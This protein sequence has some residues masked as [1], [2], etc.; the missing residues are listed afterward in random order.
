MGSEEHKLP[1]VQKKLF[2]SGFLWGAATSSHQVEGGTLN[3]WSEWEK[4]NAERLAGEAEK[5]WQ[6]WQKKKFPE[7]F[8]LQ[9]YLSGR[10]CDHYNRYE[11]DFELAKNLG[12]NAHRFSI[13]WSRIEPEEGKFSE[14]GIEHYQKVIAAL[15]NRGMEPFVTL[16]HWTNPLW[17][18]AK[19]GCESR[20]F[21]FYFSRY[22][23][24]VVERL[25]D[26][27]TFW[28][29]LNEPTSVIAD[30]YISGVW[31][32]QKKSLIATWKVFKNFAKA[33]KE[34]YKAI[35]SVSAKAQVG[36]AN[37]LQSF[38]V[39]RENSWLDKLGVLVG[40][41]FVNHRMLDMTKGHHDFLTAQFYFHNR[42]KFPRKIRLDD[43][44]VSDL[45]WEIFP[46]GIYF[47]INWLKK[48]GLPIY[49]TENGLAD[50]DDSRRTQFIKDHLYWIYKSISEGADVRGYFHWSL[51]DNF[52]WD[53]GFWPRFGLIEIDYKTLERKIRPSAYVY[54][55]IIENNRL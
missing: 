31:P 28:I 9:N 45:N 39:Y 17:L 8:D 34:A 41:Y 4:Q 21:A 37:I 6:D 27:V 23:K 40:S 52:E 22:A 19:G 38:E 25:K 42:L 47:I 7:M 35:H 36:F 11:E 44:P 50:A 16:W 13:E 53:K 5:K 46:G 49:V 12:H 1:V 24:F 55:E 14:E 26:S 54:K 10:A 2:P 51:M 32:P 43:K 20:E 48:Y 15:K 3:N 30:A 29:T 33:H 18:E